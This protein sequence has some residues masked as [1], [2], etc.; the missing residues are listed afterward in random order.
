MILAL[1]Q[2]ALGLLELLADYSPY[3]AGSVLR[4]DGQ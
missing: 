3:L 1:R 4:R 2:T